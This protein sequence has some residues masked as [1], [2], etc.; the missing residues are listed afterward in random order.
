M[1][2]NQ[3]L[4]DYYQNFSHITSL[5]HKFL[6]YLAFTLPDYK[7]SLQRVVTV[8]G[9]LLDHQLA[10]TMSNMKIRLYRVFTRPKFKKRVKRVTT[11]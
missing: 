1:R 8:Q 5:N 9:Q 2:L 10:A 4:L 11:D 7:K 3:A 6:L